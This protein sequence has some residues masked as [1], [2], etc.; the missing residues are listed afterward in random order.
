ME[1][2]SLIA[3]IIAIIVGLL[4]I[5][6]TIIDLKKEVAEDK[7]LSSL[8]GNR[9]F[10]A[11]SVIALGGAILVVIALSWVSSQIPFTLTAQIWDVQLDE[12]NSIIA[13]SSFTGT[14]NSGIPDNSLK[15][16]GAWIIS[17]L[18]K[19]H[20]DLNATGVQLHIHVPANLGKDK[21]VVQT[22]PEI[23][24]QVY[25]DRTEAGHKSR[26]P[27]DQEALSTLGKD[28]WME[29]DAPG[30]D[31]WTRHFNWSE[32]LDQNIK[33]DSIPISIG[34]EEFDGSNNSAAAWLVNYLSSYPKLKIKDPNALQILRAEIE[35]E[36]E[37]FSTNPTAQ[38]SLRTTLGVDLI[39]S[40]KYEKG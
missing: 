4:G 20:Y 12:K 19:R 31:R 7:S 34:I 14:T 30:Y 21:I 10:L 28:Y 26:L 5:F 33:L 8:L 17:Q 11:A 15:E 37:F 32:G 2:I 38:E 24:L 40:G 16:M 29:V 6:K 3:G 1:A 23:P 35:K 13:S 27:L 39:I 36:K 18:T 22:K 25:F 9:R